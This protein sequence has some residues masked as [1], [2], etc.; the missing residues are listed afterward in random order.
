MLSAIGGI[1]GGAASSLPSVSG[2]MNAPTRKITLIT[3]TKIASV[4]GNW[5]ASFA[6]SETAVGII[7]PIA[8]PMFQESPVPV[9]RIAVGKRSFRKIRIGA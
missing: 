6:T 9:A 7:P 2:T 5:L 4:I 1:A 3:P 8:K